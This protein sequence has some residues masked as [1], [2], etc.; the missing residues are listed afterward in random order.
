MNHMQKEENMMFELR[1]FP[2]RLTLELT[3]RCNL[4]CTFCPRHLVNMNLGNM[5]WE[6]FQKIVDEAAEHLPMIMVLFFRGESLTHPDLCKM[7]R[8]AKEKGI[9]PIQLASNGF[10]LSEEMGEKIIDSGLDFISFSLDT[11]DADVYK[12]TRI[13]SDLNVAMNNVVNFVKKCDRVKAEGKHVPEIQVSSVDVADYKA[14]QQKFID[15]WRQ[16]ADKVRIYMEHSADGNLGSIASIHDE[17]ETRRPCAK[18]YNDMIIYWDGTVALCNHDWENKLNIGNVKASTIESVW[19]SENYK[20]I[21]TMHEKGEFCDE[22]V[23]KHCDHW[24][25]YYSPEGFVGKAFD[26]ISR[27]G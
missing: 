26:K 3:N 2:E 20:K 27:E 18:V 8:Y 14:S 7:I 16:Y 4:E 9:G 24:R 19:H 12:Q 21:R 5:E 23:C 13:H 1:A 22:I 25:M 11:I 6:L 17:K 10:L 15:F